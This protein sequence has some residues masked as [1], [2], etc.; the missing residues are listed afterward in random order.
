MEVLPLP[1]VK[2]SFAVL[3]FP[4]VMV[5]LEVLPLP[6]VKVSL[7]VLPFPTVMVSATEFSTSPRVLNVKDTSQTY[8][9]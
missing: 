5:S 3:P 1:T 6:T 4:R 9:S 2:V 8:G 7:A